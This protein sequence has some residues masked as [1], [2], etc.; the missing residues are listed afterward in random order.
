MIIIFILPKERNPGENGSPQIIMY[1]D[2]CLFQNISLQHTNAHM[3]AV[4]YYILNILYGKPIKVCT[5]FVQ[6]TYFSLG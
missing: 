5:K 2:V 3:E 4:V 1:A 6:K